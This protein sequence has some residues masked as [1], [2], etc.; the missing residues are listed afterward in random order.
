[1]GVT[2][3]KR[4]TVTLE[5]DQYV[6]LE[7]VAAD[8]GKSLAEAARDAINHYLLGEHWRETIGKAAREAIARGKT[9]AQ[10][11]DLVRAK[12]P[13]AQTTPASVAWYRSQ[14]RRTDPRVPTDSQVRHKAGDKG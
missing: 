7:E 3:Q 12:F 4:I 10:V 6:G 2:T 8:T 13:H 1:M 5:D 14:M 9:N 11:L